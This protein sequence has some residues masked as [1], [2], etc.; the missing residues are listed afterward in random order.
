MTKNRPTDDIILDAQ[1]GGVDAK[2]VY[3]YLKELKDRDMEDARV[4]GYD[5]AGWAADRLNT[6]CEKALDLMLAANPETARELGKII[7]EMA[8]DEKKE[9]R[10]VAENASGGKIVAD[11]MEKRSVKLAGIAAALLEPTAPIENK[12]NNNNVVVKQNPVLKSTN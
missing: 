10:W 1:I 12:L 4:E 11:K 2:I 9:A 5:W 7:A 3:Q 8:A 6:A